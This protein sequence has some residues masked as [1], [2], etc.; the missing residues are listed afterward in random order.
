MVLYTLIQDRTL[1]TIWFALHSNIIWLDILVVSNACP[2][3]TNLVA[4]DLLKVG[5]TV[6]SLLQHQATRETRWTTDK[7]KHAILA[8]STTLIRYHTFQ[9]KSFSCISLFL[10]LSNHV[11]RQHVYWLAP[12]PSSLRTGRWRG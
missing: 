7:T 12:K 10:A 2:Y 3:F 5:T 8:Q 4:K 6:V 11:S 9:F 1:T